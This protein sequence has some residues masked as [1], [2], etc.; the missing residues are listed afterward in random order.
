MDNCSN[1]RADLLPTFSVDV[2]PTRLQIFE[3]FVPKAFMKEVFTT[4]MNK[5]MVKW[6]G[7]LLMDNS[8]S[9][10]VCF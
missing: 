7:L 1:S 10:L 3:F 5:S 4:Q 8:W 9:G 2:F 6:V